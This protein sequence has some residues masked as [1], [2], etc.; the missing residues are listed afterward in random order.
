MFI[1]LKL[2]LFVFS[3]LTHSHRLAEKIHELETKILSREN[4]SPTTCDKNVGTDSNNETD[5][6]KEIEILR[7]QVKGR[8]V[9][10]KRCSAEI[11]HLQH[12]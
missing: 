3:V 5:H 8:D 9:E 10:L 12:R 11:D 1:E 4:L 2:F 6:D 7:K